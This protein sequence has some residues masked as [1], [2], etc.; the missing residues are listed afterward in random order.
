MQGFA[1]VE[2]RR[3]RMGCHKC[4]GVLVAG[5]FSGQQPGLPAWGSRGSLLKGGGVVGGDR[6]QGRSSVP[7]GCVHHPDLGTIGTPSPASRL[8]HFENT[9]PICCTLKV[10]DQRL[11]GKE[12]YVDP[13][14]NPLMVIHGRGQG[15][16]PLL[17]LL[18]LLLLSST[19]LFTEAWALQLILS[20]MRV[21]ET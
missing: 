1:P 16:P 4:S 12:M 5:G 6:G 11:Q 20:K 15:P 19:S 13:T 3:G 18:L 2:L 8:C 14:V 17:W 10:A 7:R 9:E 21:T